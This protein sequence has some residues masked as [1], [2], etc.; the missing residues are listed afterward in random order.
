MA[1]SPAESPKEKKTFPIGCRSML[2]TTF[3][4]KNKTFGYMGCDDAYHIIDVETGVKIQQ[5]PLQESIG[6]VVVDTIRNVLIGHYY[7]NGTEKDNGTDHV[8]IVDL[9]NGNIVSDRQF[10]VGGE[11][12]GTYFFRDIENEY[13]LLTAD[14]VLVFVNPSTGDIIR[15]LKLDTEIYNGVYDRKKNCL[16]GATFSNGT[17]KYD[18]VVSIVTVDLN[19]GKT[20]SK[21]IAQGLIYGILGEEKDYDAETNSYV[22]VSAKNE[23]LFFDVAT[24]KLNEKHQLDFELTSLNVWRN[25]K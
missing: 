6:L 13:V 5:I 15:T 22:L 23:V 2:S 20:L 3:N 21:V 19:T 7:I 25:N 4:V 12:N 11:W 24:G 17:G 1:L 16:I 18:G 9:N 14:N 10:Y 8:L